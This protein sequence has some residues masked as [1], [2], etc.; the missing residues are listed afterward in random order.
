MK[1]L[2][3]TLAALA[4]VA[5]SA[6]AALALDGSHNSAAI[7]SSFSDVYAP[8]QTAPV[9]VKALVANSDATTRLNDAGIAA[10]QHH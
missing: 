4:I 9:A 8:A 6:T 1:T 5:T 3:L 7:N 10:S 2:N